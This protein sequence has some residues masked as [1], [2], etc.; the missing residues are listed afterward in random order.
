MLILKAF[1]Q[2]IL[3]DALSKI[4]G[5]ILRT[6]FLAF[7]SIIYALISY[8]YKIFTF[9]SQVR[10]FENARMKDLS[11]RMYIIIGVIA[12]FLVAY[13]L[14]S[15]IINPDN[16]TKGKNS[17]FSGIVKNII[18]AI[19]GIAI[20]PTIFDY[21][22]EFQER[23]LCKNVITNFFAVSPGTKDEGTD[24]SSEMS[25]KLFQSFFYAKTTDENDDSNQDDAYNNIFSDDG[26]SLA[27]AFN[28]VENDEKSLFDALGNFDK[29]FDDNELGYLYLVSTVAGLYCAYVLLGFVIDIAIRAVKLSYLQIIAPLPI[30]TLVIPNQKKVFDN[31]LKK[32]TS[33][34]M[35][36]FVR[37]IAI[38]FAAYAVRYLPEYVFGNEMQTCGEGITG[39]VSLLTRAAFILGIFGFLKQAPKLIS[40]LFPG[41]DSKGFKLGFKESFAE[42]GGFRALGAAGGFASSAAK[43]AAISGSRAYRNTNGPFKQQ[44]K[45][46][47][48]ANGALAVAAGGAAG[49]AGAVAGGAKGGYKGFV[50]A[51]EAKK[52]S[53]SRDAAGKAAEEVLEERFKKEEW[54][55]SHNDGKWLWKIR[56][57]ASE[58]I[59]ST[60]DFLSPD[61]AKY[62]IANKKHERLAGVASAKKNVTSLDDDILS[63]EKYS[64]K[65][66][67]SD[68][69]MDQAK[70]DDDQ[71]AKYKDK[72]WK[73]IQQAKIDAEKERDTSRQLLVEAQAMRGDERFSTSYISNARKTANE[74]VLAAQ[75]K[76]KG[77]RTQLA[78]DIAKKELSFALEQK[79]IAD[80]M[81]ADY[82][83]TPEYV[84]KLKKERQ[85]SY[86]EAVAKFDRASEDVN[87]FKKYI[88]EELHSGRLDKDI[89][90]DN[91]QKYKNAKN[92]LE[93]KIKGVL[94]DI[95][96]IN[97]EKSKEA[98]EKATDAIASGDY[99]KLLDAAS[100][101][102]SVDLSLISELNQIADNMRKQQEN[103]K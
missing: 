56:G 50:G 75:E 11:D 1:G 81:Q 16:A 101:I 52:W 54:D 19:V 43:N 13:A 93:T 83:R 20:V 70:W 21:A 39:V 48:F 29:A 34:F 103:K 95:A 94:S 4:F 72:S 91:A 32:T 49:V 67:L 6:I 100:K 26:V 97:D 98:Y 42:V 10:L 59:D 82:T 14:I 84:E 5:K 31:W 51:K 65:L 90:D 44:N 9:L 57:K 53:D 92:E 2:D 12:L 22:Y 61:K 71:K 30:M 24:F 45:L 58:A 23:V 66:K 55:E 89:E 8:L 36:V 64:G 86:D 87:K 63:S 3:T 41:F 62:A 102:N 68:E 73:D 15:A 40:E 37:V 7:D 38:T 28:S 80:S 76:L 99:A 79:Q 35:E 25:V 60:K 46:A 77:A 17:S 85:E 74:N 18:F 27:D 96:N 69:Y 78:A 47:K 88:K 33:C